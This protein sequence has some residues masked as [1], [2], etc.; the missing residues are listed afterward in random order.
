[1]TSQTSDEGHTVRVH[2]STSVASFDRPIIE[3]LYAPIASIIVGLCGSAITTRSM[4]CEETLTQLKGYDGLCVSE[5]YDSDSSTTLLFLDSEDENVCSSGA[6]LVKTEIFRAICQA[7]H[8][9]ALVSFD[10]NA[11]FAVSHRPPTEDEQRHGPLLALVV[12]RVANHLADFLLTEFGTEEC[13]ATK[14]KNLWAI[15]Y[16]FGARAIGG[17]LDSTLYK[18]YHALHG[19]SLT[20]PTAQHAVASMEHLPLSSPNDEIHQVEMVV[21]ESTLATAQLYRCIMRAYGTGRKSP[22]RAALEFVASALPDMEESKRSKVLRNFLFSGESEYFSHRDV[23]SLVNNGSDLPA[24]PDWVWVTHDVPDDT[25]LDTEI[26]DALVVRKGI[27]HQL[28]QGPLPSLAG[29]SAD[30]AK[31]AKQD[32]NVEERVITAR[33]EDELS[34]KFNAIVDDLCYGEPVNSKAWFD[35]SQCLLMKADLIADRL[36]L[37]KGFSRTDGFQIPS[38]RVKAGAQLTLAELID[39]QEREYE[40]NLMGWKPHL[41]KDLSAYIRYQWASFPSL[42][43]CFEELGACGDRDMFDGSAMDDDD[44]SADAWNEIGDLYEKGDYCGWQQAGGG[45]FVGALRKMAVRCKFLALYLL[46][47]QDSALPS[48]SFLASEISESLGAVYY[49]ELMGS[50]MYGYPMHVMTDHWKRQMAETALS[51]FQFAV[52][53]L[54]VAVSDEDLE[55]KQTWDLVFMRGKVS[56][57][58]S[59][60]FKD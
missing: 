16:P 37:S 12:C 29:S 35:A 59:L 10:V 20:G 42:R 52:D 4:I 51:C 28:A 15:D 1:M 34:K 43:A 44:F 45:L 21:P 38:Q 3:V 2:G 9:L 13:P 30:S 22:P 54:G 25:N 32:M 58:L 17:L 60:V 27:C 6:K 8:C 26:Q 36:G 33:N 48:E 47:R 23:I 31:T 41:G 46:R 39:D 40:R 50:Q 53:A 18:A 19:I 56:L 55:A 11:K 57:L 49:T 14:R 5:F 24:A 7:V